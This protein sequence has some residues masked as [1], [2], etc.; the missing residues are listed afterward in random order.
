MRPRHEPCSPVHRGKHGEWYPGRRRPLAASQSPR[1]PYP[2]VPVPDA[3]GDDR[4]GLPNPPHPRVV[5]ATLTLLTGASAGRLLAVAPGG[6]IIGRAVEASLVVEDACVS[7]RHARVARN[8]DGGFYVEDLRSTNGTFV[9][10]KRVGISLLRG[11]ETESSL[12]R[13]SGF[14]RDNR[15]SQSLYRGLYDSSVRDP[16][17][18]VFK[19]KYLAVRFVT[20][21][22]APG[23]LLPDAGTTS[24]WSPP[25]D[26]AA[27]IRL[28]L[29]E[30]LRRAIEELHVSALGQ[31]PRSIGPPPRRL[32]GGDDRPRRSA[33][34]RALRLAT[35]VTSASASK[36]FDK[37][38]PET[39]G[40]GAN[41]VL[42]RT[43]AVNAAAA[44]S[45]SRS[46]T[47]R[48]RS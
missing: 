1:L 39:C 43:D 25:S 42:R 31:C 36:G 44:S 18:H 20:E 7:R 37:M 17:T 27:S 41:S 5:R 29:G 10:S 33:S 15:R 47:L 46:A 26:W 11:E 34:V 13:S 8:S 12:A 4:P 23:T 48:T 24:S 38:H 40:E 45:G 9:G 16:L 28:R 3:L 14:V 35:A 2:I 30:R 21:V 19:R 6:A 32:L 22:S